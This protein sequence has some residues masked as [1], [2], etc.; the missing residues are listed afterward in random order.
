MQAIRKVPAGP[1]PVVVPA[2]MRFAFSRSPSTVHRVR[3]RC[4]HSLPR[5]ERVM[6]GPIIVLERCNWDGA[7][8]TQPEY[9][10]PC[11]PYGRR[12][13]KA[14]L[15]ALDKTHI[16]FPDARVGL[17]NDVASVLA[18]FAAQVDKRFV[19][20]AACAGGHHYVVGTW[21][22]SKIDVNV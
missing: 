13:A 20:C 12:L 5:F 9:C 17:C 19:I 3:T 6:V 10:T 22:G 15:C 8:P 4:H 2:A 1:F 14:I 11:S 7:P 21:N 16:I 18:L